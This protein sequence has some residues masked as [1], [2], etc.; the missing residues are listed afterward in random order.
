[1]KKKYSYIYFILLLIVYNC[2]YNKSDSSRF[3]D[4]ANVKYEYFENGRVKSKFSYLGNKLEG[5][6]FFYDST[7]TLISSSSYIDGLL[8]GTTVKYGK[9]GE[10][11]YS[12]DFKRGMKH[13]KEV[14]Y[15]KNSKKKSQVYYEYDKKVSQI[16]R[17]DLN[18][19]IIP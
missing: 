2:S 17:W 16:I 13:G 3:S 19:K 9:T 1:M 11:A 8:D 14:F 12:I 18:G 4:Q 10:I 7:G 6:S 15:H 5:E